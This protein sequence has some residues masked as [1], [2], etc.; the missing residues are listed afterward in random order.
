MRSAGSP[1]CIWITISTLR[2]VAATFGRR[3]V[4]GLVGAECGE[5]VVFGR[6]CCP[7]H[8]GPERLCDLHGEMAHATCCG[9]YQNTLSRCDFP[10][11]D[12]HLPGRER[13]QGQGRGLGE[14]V[15]DNEPADLAFELDAIARTAAQDALLFGE[16]A[17]YDRARRILAA[18]LD[19]V[20]HRPASGT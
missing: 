16:S 20:T 6:A 3:V 1:P 17:P 14:I 9:G 19:A 7:D 4:D 10:D 13:G 18:R 5:E 2:T 12:K 11:I 15:I 8:V